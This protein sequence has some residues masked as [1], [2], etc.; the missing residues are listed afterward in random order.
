MYL[1]QNTL[2]VIFLII[3]FAFPICPF[4]FFLMHPLNV[5]EMQGKLNGETNHENN[6]LIAIISTIA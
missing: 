4:I 6:Q 2:T 5:I 3:F 1:V